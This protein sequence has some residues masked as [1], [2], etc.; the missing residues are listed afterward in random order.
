[1][2]TFLELSRWLKSV[3]LKH[4]AIPLY[5][6]GQIANIEELRNAARTN[7]LDFLDERDRITLQQALQV[8]V[9]P[10]EQI[11]LHNARR[12]DAPTN[13]PK[14]R[15]NLQKALDAAKPENRE[16]ARK[17]LL[18]DIYAQ[19]NIGSRESKWKTWCI[20]AKEWGHAPVPIT[21]ELAIDAATSFKEGDYRSARQYFHRA[22]EEHI[23]L[24]GQELPAD[25]E[26]LV[27]QV[28]RSTERG[29][30]P[31]AFKDS[32]MLELLRPVAA[33]DNVEAADKSFLSNNTAAKVDMVILGCW[34]MTRGI[35]L[36]MAKQVHLWAEVNH[37]T[38]FW[39]LPVDKT[40][41]G[42]GCIT[43]PH[44]CCCGSRLD[45]ICPYHAACR[46]LRRLYKAFNFKDMEGQQFEN[47]PLFP[48][49]HG[50]HMTKTEVIAILRAVIALTGTAL[51][52]P[53][54]TG[55]MRDKFG[56]HVM[57][58]S[59]AQ[60]MARA[61]I[62][63]YIIQLYGRWGSWAI[64]RYVQ[65]AYLH[66]PANVAKTVVDNLQETIEKS[67]G[68]SVT[69]ILDSSEKS[70]LSTDEVLKLIEATIHKVLAS[71]RKFIGNPQTN[72]A[73]IPAISEQS[74]QSAFWHAAC[75]W[76]YGRRNHVGLSKIEG[77]WTICE[78]C[79]KA[80]AYYNQLD[81]D[82]D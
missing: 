31:A 8:Q 34:W 17:R 71:Q 50:E 12:P 43:R 76:P 73:H 39:T 9:R 66:G 33:T 26:R 57:R 77:S 36:A 45:T 53:G 65:E 82:E 37:N 7:Q 13:K 54:P 23:Q 40:H 32:F 49:E 38:V 52:R 6:R 67:T 69:T 78:N 62:E 70:D 24:T 1:M 44:K 63:L 4:L 14:L 72:K 80:K 2:A 61:G 46:H 56:E 21:R 29:M 60:L 10:Q 16:A 19:S 47:F 58:V 42:G 22:K 74:V 3:D 35:E 11:A 75:R 64:E 51:Q 68:E 30:G 41:T 18:Q 20:I 55:N 15:G 79:V 27:A 5:S 59:G 48:T 25:I 28:I 81:C